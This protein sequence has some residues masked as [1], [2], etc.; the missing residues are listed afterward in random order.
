MAVLSSD[1]LTFSDGSIPF[2]VGP[3]CYGDNNK[4]IMQLVTDFGVWSI[5]G[6]TDAP[7]SGWVTYIILPVIPTSAG[8][9]E[10]NFQLAFGFTSKKM[11]YRY[12]NVSSGTTNWKEIN[13]T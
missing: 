10:Y 8:L 3:E 11:Y 6:A 4:S 5:I 2:R 12:W 9:A 7:E 13:M 1:A